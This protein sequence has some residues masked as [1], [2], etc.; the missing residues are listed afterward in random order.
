MS[1][2]S[3]AEEVFTAGLLHDLGKFVLEIYSPKSYGQVIKSRK[4]TDQSLVEVERDAFGFDHA[5][6]GE[7]F[8]FSWRFPGML[9]RSIGHHHEQID[10][11]CVR[12]SSDHAVALVALADHLAHTL[13]PAV[14]CD[15]GFDAGRVDWKLLIKAAGL[16]DDTVAAEHGAFKDAV[17]K[18]S[19]YLDLG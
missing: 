2:Y 17:R 18:S 10:T 15:L 6:L 14:T 3:Q 8:G 16:T 11:T 4:D 1:G 13:V 9:T 7:A 5:V 19:I 12:G